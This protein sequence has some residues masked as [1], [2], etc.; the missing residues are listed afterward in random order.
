MDAIIYL[1]D[2]GFIKT[3]NVSVT[4]IV[5]LNSD[6]CIAVIGDVIIKFSDVKYI[7]IG[8]ENDKNKN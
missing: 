8:E 2:G 1:K 7:K 3:E 5:Q 6:N 4:D